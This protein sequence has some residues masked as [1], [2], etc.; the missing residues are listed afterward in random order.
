M[1]FIDGG[2]FLSFTSRGPAG[3]R[4]VVLVHGFTQSGRSWERVATA[5][6]KHYE[7]LCLDAPGHGG[8]SGIRADLS[9]GAALIGRSAGKAAYVGYSM[10]GRYCMHLALSQPDLVDALVLLGAHPGIED[11]S[12]RKARR[13]SDDLLATSLE[14]TEAMAAKG[15]S[16]ESPTEA[17]AVDI[18]GEELPRLREFLD[19]WL[20]Q[21][22][23]STLSTEQAGLQAR[24][25]DNTCAGLA[26]SLRLAGTGTQTP[27][28]NRLGELSMPVLIVAGE[29]DLA[30]SALGRRT[31]S[32]I[33][34][35]ARF[36]S[37]AGAGHAV[38]LEQPEQ[39]F[40]LVRSFLDDLYD[41][42][43]GASQG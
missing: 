35:N 27:L 24:L 9:E 42:D 21:P 39:F 41:G 18:R 28:W 38:H 19:R 4:R 40:H 43:R 10:G 3:A 36:V 32:A 29:H 37:V 30:Y 12:Q 22:L 8:S 13:I 15:S 16:E 6:A 7:V 33:G 26:S 2:T 5:L 17:G 1:P 31:A 34:D 25:E 20:S 11:P 23:F 14:P